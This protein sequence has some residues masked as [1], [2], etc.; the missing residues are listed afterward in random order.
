M[1]M[2]LVKYIVHRH[3]TDVILTTGLFASLVCMTLCCAAA[4]Y[5]INDI[6]DVEMDRINKPGK[7]IFESV[8]SKQQGYH[9]YAIIT[10][11]GLVVTIPLLKIYGAP[12]LI[13]Y[14]LC[15]AGLAW[16][17]FRL[18]KRP[19]LGNLLIG[20]FCALVIYLPWLPYAQQ[21][22]FGT[23]A[24]TQ[25]I[26]DTLALF[27]FL[28]TLIREIIKDIEDIT[29]DRVAGAHT[30]PIAAG[31]DAALRLVALLC[32]LVCGY[33]VYFLNQTQ[34]PW[35]KYHIAM[36]VLICLPLLWVAFTS[37]RMNFDE[38]GKNDHV[39]I[40]RNSLTLKA[41]MIIGSLFLSIL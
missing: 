24:D 33:L 34:Q 27:A 32:V 29:G 15:T 6:L 12:I 11:L 37:I 31:V 3:D 23:Y 2:Y 17:A 40:R 18:K 7:N 16:Y 35:T 4:G 22:D 5:I 41:V 13:T 9:A 30:L 19:L 1:I 14:L 10:I 8:M 20:A 38:E 36:V 39:T 28:V 21:T 25:T 26:I